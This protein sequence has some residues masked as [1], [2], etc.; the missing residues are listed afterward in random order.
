MVTVTISLSNPFDYFQA[1]VLV[2]RKLLEFYGAAF[3]VL[4]KKGAKL[5]MEMILENGK[6]PKI[7]EDFLK[8]AEN[9]RR[10]VQK[11]TWEIVEDMKIMLYDQESKFL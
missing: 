3:E 11:A 6:L 4:T 9:L 1:L 10:L 2:Y 8:H 7:V 5:V